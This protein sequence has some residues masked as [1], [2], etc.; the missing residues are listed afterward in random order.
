MFPP[1]MAAK[2]QFQAMMAAQAAQL[3]GDQWETASTMGGPGG[4]G[5]GGG[6]MSDAGSVYGVPPSGAASM[7]GGLFGGGGA[8]YA[9]S[10]YGGGGGGSQWGG[11]EA[12]GGYSRSEYG[13]GAMGTGGR[14]GHRHVSSPLDYGSSSAMGGA[15][16]RMRSGSFGGE[17]RP[18]LHSYTEHSS[19]A[20]DYYQQ[21]PIHSSQLPRSQQAGPAVT[22]LRQR[23]SSAPSFASNQHHHSAQQRHHQPSSSSSTRPSLQGTS[24]SSSTAS[25]AVTSTR[26]RAPSISSNA[27]L[28]A[29]PQP[30]FARERSG[31]GSRSSVRSASPALGPP[32]TSWRANQGSISPDP[33]P[34]SGRRR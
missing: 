2:Q 14:S 1:Q 8:G 24:T 18:P 28:I 32:P 6:G 7:Y 29:P 20:T 12:G 31:S 22:A 9:A 27:E 3:A 23:M 4:G 5:R 25:P 11:S 19:M 34:S 30:P 17:P 10:A 21:S 15:A 33:K 13:G 26:K 16:G